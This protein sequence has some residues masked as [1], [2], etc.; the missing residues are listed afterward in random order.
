MKSDDITGDD[1]VVTT[2]LSDSDESFEKY[3]TRIYVPDSVKQKL[4]NYSELDRQLA[5]YL[6][7]MTFHRHGTILLAGPPG[8]GK[9]SLAKGAADKIAGRLDQRTL[10]RRVRIQKLFSSGFGDTPELV[11]E[12]FAELIE[13]AQHSDA[14]QVVLLDEV[15]SLFSNRALLAGDTDPMDAVRA[16]NRALERLDDLAEYPNVFVIATSNQP[17]IVDNAFADRTD[18]QLHIGLPDAEQRCAICLDV[19]TRLNETFEADLPTESAE[20]DRLVALS[21]GFSGRRIRK[22]VYSALASS[23]MT[24]T[25]PG[26]LD[27]T[28]VCEEF[29]RKRVDRSHTAGENDGGSGIT[30][31]TVDSIKS[32][33]ADFQDRD[34]RPAET[35]SASTADGSSSGD[36]ISRSHEQQSQVAGESREGTSQTRGAEIETSDAPV[37]SDD[38]DRSESELDPADSPGEESPD[39]TDRH[40]GSESGEASLP[41]RGPLRDRSDDRS[42]DDPSNHQTTQTDTAETTDDASD[43]TSARFSRRVVFDSTV[44]APHLELRDDVLEFL[45]KTLDAAGCDGDGS[46]AVLSTAESEE[47]LYELCMSRQLDRIHV[48]AGDL[49][50]DIE[51]VCDHTGRSDLRIPDA[52]AIPSL[53]SDTRL[54]YTFV[55]TGNEDSIDTPLPEAAETEI[56]LIDASSA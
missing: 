11:D 32:I 28:Q 47:F 17:D 40:E 33:E 35:E 14:Y 54:Q 49:V 34:A 4:V 46:I 2:D 55:L 8:T 3:W 24:A 45:E 5:E 12:A 50:L 29:E 22:L 6:D 56:E 53:P 37:P 7:R 25:D 26:Q 43:T 15:E 27:Y 52:E 51:V 39:W 42:V 36:S 38:T 23:D 18:D 19:F 31:E 10:F 16:V 13:L 30:D 9:T 44:R 41:E 48:T 20:L 21:E 1:F